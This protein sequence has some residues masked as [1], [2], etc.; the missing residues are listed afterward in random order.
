MGYNDPGFVNHQ[1]TSTPTLDKLAANGVS[2]SRHYTDS[3]CSPSRAALLSGI[4]PAR[5]GFHPEGLALPKQIVTLPQLLKNNG[6]RTY[7]FGKWHAGDLIGDA[8]PEKHGFDHWF[9]MLSHFYLKG[10]THNGHLVASTPTY[11]DPWLQSDSTPLKQ[12]HGS[13]DDLLTAKAIDTIR[14]QSDQPWFIYVPFFSPHTPTIPNDTFRAKYPDTP[15][16]RYRAVLEQLDSNIAALLAAVDDAGEH[17]D[18]LVVFVSDNGATGKY[19]PSNEPFSGSKAS[20]DEGGIRTPL[21]VYWP[22]HWQG[23]R[24]VNEPKYIA[25]IY[26]TIAQALG[27]K[28]PHPIDGE[29][30]FGKRKSPLYWYSQSAFSDSFSTLSADGRWRLAGEGNTLQLLHYP[31]PLGPPQPGQN[32]AMQAKLLGQFIAWRD[33]ATTLVRDGK[34][35]AKNGSESIATPFRP[36]FSLGFSFVAP[37]PSEP[38]P[39]VLIDNRQLRLSY[40]AGVFNLDVDDAKLTIPYQLSGRC[41]SVYLNFAV[42]QDNTIFYGNGRSTITLYVNNNPPNTAAFKIDRINDRNFA[43]LAL[44]DFMTQPGGPVIRDSIDIASRMLS[45][46][47]VQ[48]LLARQAGKYCSP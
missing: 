46:D 44:A 3:S 45:G 25:D 40:G 8:S 35:L 12:Y 17:D 21:I 34:P 23:G 30:I 11:V 29:N 6:Y 26:P 37:P 7:L 14:H 33:L 9:G 42:A 15:N 22:K 31:D 4:N 38:G 20:Y 43:P 39:V 18:T 5:L 1:Q 24:Q 47:E 36:T 27:L 48:R 2:F 10:N 13:I 32:A 16:G 41:N 28:I 19:F